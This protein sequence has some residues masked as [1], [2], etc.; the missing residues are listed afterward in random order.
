MPASKTEVQY[1]GQVLICAKADVA[2]IRTEPENDHSLEIPSVTVAIS[3]AQIVSEP[4]LGAPYE[5]SLNGA[6][7]YVVTLNQNDLMTADSLYRKLRTALLANETMVL[8]ATM[9]AGPISAT[10]EEFQIEFVPPSA[11]FGWVPG[12]KRASTLT[13]TGKG[14]SATFNTTPTP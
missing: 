6:L 11:A 13:F 4:T 2:T 10:N 7:S 9:N 12:Q 3:A 1:H 8:Y 5:D 14:G